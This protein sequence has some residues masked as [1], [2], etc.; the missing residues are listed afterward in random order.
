MHLSEKFLNTVNRQISTLNAEPAIEPRS[1]FCASE[2]YIAGLIYVK[3]FAELTTN[4]IH[5]LCSQALL[6]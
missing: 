2:R 1:A 3:F 4:Y 5:T 6:T